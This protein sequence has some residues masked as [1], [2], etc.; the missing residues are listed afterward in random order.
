[1]AHH[2]RTFEISKAANDEDAVPALHKSML[3]LVRRAEA[4]LSA[5]QLGV[6]LTVYLEPGPHTVR[7]L[8]ARFNICKPAVT[9]ALNRLGELDLTRRKVDPRDRRSVLVQRTG[10]GWQLLEDLRGAA[11]QAAVDAEWADA[12][13]PR[14]LK[15]VVTHRT[16]YGHG[17]AANTLVD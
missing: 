9:R 7:S 15:A 17:F 2:A 13:R 1:M 12:P 16:G 8:S 14:W 5:R 3:F 10:A 11:G 6:F 4:D